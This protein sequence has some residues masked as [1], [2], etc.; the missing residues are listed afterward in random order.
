MAEA[1][2]VAAKEMEDGGWCACCE[3][4]RHAMPETRIRDRMLK[5]FDAY[6]KPEGGDFVLW[7]WGGC[8]CQMPSTRGPRVLALGFMAAMVEAGDA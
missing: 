2:R 8:C 6:F 1:F 4:I 7:W 5:E 3:A